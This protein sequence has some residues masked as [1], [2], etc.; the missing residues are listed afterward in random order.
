MVRNSAVAL[1]RCLAALR[2]AELRRSRLI[3]T[4]VPKARRTMAGTARKGT[5]ATNDSS[6]VPGNE[7]P[8]VLLDYYRQMSL[9]RAFELRASEMYARAKIGGYCHL[10]LGEEA[11]VVGLMDALGKSDYLFMTYRDHGYALARGME[12]GRVMAE[13]FGKTTGVSKGRAWS[14]GNGCGWSSS[15]PT[16]GRRRGRRRRCAIR[17]TPR[18]ARR[19]RPGGTGCWPSSA[20]TWTTSGIGPTSKSTAMLRYRRSR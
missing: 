12:P 15:W 16:A 8:E 20:A 19:S 9:I 18:W 3:V 5:V 1:T 7:S 4:K 6:M 2:C 13:L 17:R 10:N 11:T 14:R